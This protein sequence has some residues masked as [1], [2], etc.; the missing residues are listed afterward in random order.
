MTKP[1]HLACHEVTV[2]TANISDT[3]G[4]GTTAAANTNGTGTQRQARQISQQPS[5]TCFTL[6]LKLY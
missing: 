4:T 2:I 3:A 1:Q 5:N 6:V